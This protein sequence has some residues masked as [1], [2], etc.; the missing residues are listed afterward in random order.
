MFW[1]LISFLAGLVAYGLT[2]LYTAIVVGLFTFLV[3]P[4]IGGP[5]IDSNKVARFLVWPFWN[6]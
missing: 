6:I 5:A 2:S 1:L 4:K 3:I